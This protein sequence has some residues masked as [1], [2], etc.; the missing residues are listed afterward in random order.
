VLAFLLALQSSARRQR[1]VALLHHRGRE[2]INQ[3]TVPATSQRETTTA[4]PLTGL[5]NK[6]TAVTR[7]FPAGSGPEQIAQADGRDLGSRW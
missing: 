4:A 3:L 7:R 6:K 2:K 1:H 5:R